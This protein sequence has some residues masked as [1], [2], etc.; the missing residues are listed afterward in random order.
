MRIRGEWIRSWL[1]YN[2]GFYYQRIIGTR[3][4][5]Y[6]PSDSALWICANEQSLHCYQPLIARG[7]L[8]RCVQRHPHSP[9]YAHRNLLSLSGAYTQLNLVK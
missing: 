2:L 8:L 7:Q 5:T 6:V 3:H 4:C 9:E 1:C